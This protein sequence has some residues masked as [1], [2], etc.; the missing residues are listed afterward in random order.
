MK[1]MKQY[2]MMFMVVLSTMFSSRAA[3][4]PEMLRGAADYLEKVDRLELQLKA[5]QDVL[6]GQD[7]ASGHEIKTLTDRISL[8]EAK[9]DLR[10]PRFTYVLQKDEDGFADDSWE[11]I[12]RQG[13]AEQLRYWKHGEA[14]WGARFPSP[15]GPGW[16]GT[17]SMPVIT[18]LCVEPE[19][20]FHDTVRVPGRFQVAATARWGSTLRLYCDGDNVLVD[21]I[22][23][24][25]ATKQ[26]IGIYVEPSTQVG[27]MI[28][29][30]FEQ[31]IENLILV[32]MGNVMPVYLAQNQDRFWMLNNNI[33]Q[34]QN[35]NP[36]GQIGIK[37]GPPLRGRDYPF[38][39]TQ[40]LDGNVFLADPRIVG[41]QFE[42]PHNNLLPQACVFMSGNNV[43]IQDTNIYGWKCGPYLHSDRGALIS[44]LVVHGG[45]TADGRR[46][47]PD[48]EIL[49]YI[50][51]KRTDT[52]SFSGVAGGYPGWYLPKR[53]QVPRT[54]GWHKAGEYLF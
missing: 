51:S 1:H 29:R 5:V 11:D 41:T 25:V 24:G 20:M 2:L 49:S 45:L 54:A 53:S 39:A 19:Y 30:P 21:D 4:L 22:A 48:E 50:V 28:S 16:L 34:H 27:E 17:S 46:F 12:I 7:T 6:A 14:Y 52:A 8:L 10:V 13:Q 3:D 26:P 47:C 42:G 38:P 37:H 15:S 9:P 36:S 33:Q 44:S 18:I 35:S 40:L 23:Y 43:M 31:G 32:A